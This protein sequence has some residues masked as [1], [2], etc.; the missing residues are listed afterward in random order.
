MT[1]LFSDGFSLP[2]T[3]D[4]HFH[5]IYDTAS[6]PIIALVRTFLLVK[7]THLSNIELSALTT[8][9]C[10]SAARSNCVPVTTK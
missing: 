6:Q 4:R 9:C 10:I 3:L 8:P 1:G 7:N 5:L 2:A